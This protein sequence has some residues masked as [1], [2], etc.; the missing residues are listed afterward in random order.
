MI[1]TKIIAADAENMWIGT[2]EKG[3]C[4]YNFNQKRFQNIDQNFD[5]DK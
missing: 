2:Y 5:Y 3:V 4:Q 1:V